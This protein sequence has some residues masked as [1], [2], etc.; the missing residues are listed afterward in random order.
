MMDLQNWLCISSTEKFCTGVKLHNYQKNDFYHVYMRQL[1][2]VIIQPI[3]IKF[4]TDIK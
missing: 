4:D 3:S 2:S 1:F